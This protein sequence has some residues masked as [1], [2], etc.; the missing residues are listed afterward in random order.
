MTMMID[1]TR[2]CHRR[3]TRA[4]E[5]IFSSGLA[6]A[7]LA[8]ALLSGVA[9]CDRGRKQAPGEDQ[10]LATVGPYRITRADLEFR[11]T[12]L[13][14]GAQESLK[15]PER[16]ALLLEQM[17]DEKLIRLAAESQKLDRE[18]EYQRYV[19]DLST[20]LLS[21]YYN[22]KVLAPRALPDSAEILRY[23]EE[24]PAEF[25]VGERVTA[26]Q[27]VVATAGEAAEVRRRL[28]AGAD[29]ESLLPRSID[30][31]TKNL[32]GALG[33]VTRGAPVRGV[34]QNDAFIEAVMAV[35]A[36]QVSEPIRTDK[37]Y[38]VVRVEAREPERVRDLEAVRPALERRLQS[39]KF[40]DLGQHL[41]DSLRAK[42]KVEI[43]EKTLLGEEGYR[44][45][46][47]KKLFDR[48][49]STEDAA[50]RIRMYEQIVAEH[51]GTRYAAQ[52]QFMIGFVYAEEIKDKDKARAA[53]EQVL[54]RYPDSELVDSAK[55]M[56]KYMDSPS[57][58]P[59]E[60]PAGVG[61]GAPAGG[62]R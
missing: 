46:S 60:P 61:A 48:A 25:R 24:H 50:E 6:R 32:G 30:V 57:P 59:G 16:Q 55:Y 49:Q 29:F 1:S 42:Y 38:H 53:L 36:G 23:Y 8:V 10:V 33:Y 18:P 44:E 15:D 22:D 14:E 51:A 62:P 12:Q 9:G 41:V 45:H 26:R 19:N 39:Q 20:Q 37:G 40:K 54:A 4:R 21:R 28:V 2:G 43:D 5:R 35:P 7:A 56:L 3:R 13:P 58:P 17:V 47:A 11:M 52:A 31:Q 27:I 34:G